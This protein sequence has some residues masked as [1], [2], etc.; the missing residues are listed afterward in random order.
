MMTF[1]FKKYKKWKR[2]YPRENVYLFFSRWRCPCYW[3]PSTYLNGTYTLSFIMKVCVTILCLGCHYLNHSSNCLVLFNKVVRMSLF[4]F[5]QY[6]LFYTSTL[7]SDLCF[8][9]KWAYWIPFFIL[10]QN[11]DAHQNP[12]P[13]IKTNVWTKQP[14]K[15]INFTEF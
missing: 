8:Q 2:N 12:K 10:G 4:V 11:G 14:V 15:G 3:L 7:K 9:L 1:S 5:D 6:C 13:S